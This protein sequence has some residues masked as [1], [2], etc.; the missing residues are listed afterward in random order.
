[1][2]MK[3]LLFSTLFP[4]AANPTLGVFVENRMRHLIKYNT[5]I[6]VTVV[7]PVPW[8]PFKWR[9]FGKYAQYASAPHYEERE[10]ICVYHPRYIVLPKIGM[11]LTPSFLYNAAKRC[12]EKLIKTGETYDLIDSHYLYPDGVAASKLATYFSLPFVMTARGS[13][14][15]EIGLMEKP[16]NLMVQAMKQAYHTITVSNNLRNDLIQMGGAPGVITTL[17]N[18]VDLNRFY[19]VKKNKLEFLKGKKKIMLF[20]GWLI[21]RKRL[22][23]VLK[24]TDLIPDLHTVIVGDGPL[25]AELG[26]DVVKMS[27]NERVS[28]IGQQKPE[29]MPELFS[30]ADILILPSDREGWA[31]VLLEAMACGTPVVSRAVGGAVDLITNDIAGRVVDSE[32]AESFAEAVED[33]FNKYPDRG[34]VRKFAEKYDWHSTSAGQYEIFSNAISAYRSLEDGA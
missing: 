28:F 6:S 13:D 27:I 23:I 33:L 20:A 12:I 31:N 17:R 24:V 9:G 3:I 29:D 11:M 26:A 18:G 34:D 32:H 22:D 8:F 5:D 10:G 16:K 30:N 15:T 4:N 2:N 21:P 14:V 25:R 7:A 19:E 1:M